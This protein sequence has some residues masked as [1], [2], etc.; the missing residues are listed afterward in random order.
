[1]ALGHY[2]SVYYGVFMR[3][4]KCGT[5]YLQAKQA[6][7]ELE[8]FARKLGVTPLSEQEIEESKQFNKELFEKLLKRMI[9]QLRKSGKPVPDDLP[10]DVSSA[11]NQIAGLL[12]DND[13]GSEGSF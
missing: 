10:K 12:R 13:K 6:Q 11:I 9:S 1:V 4:I 2:D 3:I 5:P 7:K 8:Q